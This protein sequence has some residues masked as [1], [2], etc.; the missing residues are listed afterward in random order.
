MIE[1]IEVGKSY[2]SERSRLL[3]VL[4]VGTGKVFYLD[5]EYETTSSIAYAESNWSELPEEKPVKKL[6]AYMG[7]NYNIVFF[8]ESTGF[9]QLE[10]AEE[11]DIEFPRGE[12]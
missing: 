1:K 2:I 9:L 12:E 10:R 8:T 4:F 3:E 5:G 11:Y 7:A 6:Y